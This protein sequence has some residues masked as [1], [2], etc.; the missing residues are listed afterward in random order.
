MNIFDRL[1]IFEMANNH[2]GDVNHGLKI[3]D[4]FSKVSKKFDFQFGIKLQYRQLDTFIHPDY[5]SRNDI[6]YI[7]RF[8]ETKLNK[9]EFKT[10]KDAIKS[11]GLLA[12]CTPFDEASVDLIEEHEFDIIKVASFH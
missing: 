2:M 5:R 8:L 3:I 12:I 4:E 7:K 10:L 11:A 6:K 9:D 1:F